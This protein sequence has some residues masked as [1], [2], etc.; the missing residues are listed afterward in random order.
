MT[1]LI[2][3]Q[4]NWWAQPSQPATLLALSF[5]LSF[6]PASYNFTDT[7]IAQFFAIFH[8]HQNLW[9]A[10]AVGIT[11]GVIFYLRW[12]LSSDGFATKIL[13]GR[14]TSSF[15][16]CNSKPRKP[17]RC[18]ISQIKFVHVL[19]LYR[20]QN[21]WR[22]LKAQRVSDSVDHSLSTCWDCS[23]NPSGIQINDVIGS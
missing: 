19:L 20:S 14:P 3:S 2:P 10:L 12:C 5:F 9:K 4:N 6:F 1:L 8:C 21:Q 23:P 16:S 11:M 7:A 13:S 22:H 18:K 17:N 15:F